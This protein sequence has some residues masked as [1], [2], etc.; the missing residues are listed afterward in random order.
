VSRRGVM[1]FVA[2]SVIWGIPYLLIK[3]AVGEVG[4]VALVFVRTAIGALVLLPFAVHRRA[5]G[6][7]VR[8]WP[9]VLAYAAIE[10]IGPWLLLSDAEQHVS[11]SLA[12][13]VIAA[14][15][16]IGAGIAWLVHRERLGGAQL[17]GLVVGLA[18]VVALVG[19]DLAG[20]ADARAVVELL[21]TAVGYAVGP[22]IISRYL[23]AVP[24]LGVNA[25]ALTTAAL[26]T[27]PFALPRLPQQVPS[28]E[29]VA[30]ILVLGLVCTA[31]AFL[32]FFALIRE[33][34]PARATVIT[35]VNPAVALALG[36]T[37]LDEP[38]TRGILVGFPLVLAGSV[39]ATWQRPAPVRIPAGVAGGPVS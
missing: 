11:S 24:A 30:S 33:I 20:G 4:P 39:L 8:H 36:V 32:G 14:V 34:G 29:A 23:G 5:L 9:W 13:L 3:V 6:A 2:M 27:L 7:A 38:L 31:V 19:L 17:L 16:L 37:L 21:L 26:I 18:G 10:I 22:V 35:Y 25:L 28:V 12:G 1:L 15:P